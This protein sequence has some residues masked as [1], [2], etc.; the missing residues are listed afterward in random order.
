MLPIIVIIIIIIDCLHSSSFSSSSLS[1]F[2]FS[3]SSSSL[4]VLGN[5]TM[6][7]VS[8]SLAGV[9]G[10][11]LFWCRD[12][13][14]E[15]LCRERFRINS[16]PVRTCILRH[17]LMQ[18]VLCQDLRRNFCFQLFSGQDL[19]MEFEAQKHFGV[20]TCGGKF[21][22]VKSFGSNIFGSRPAS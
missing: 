18:L 2:S 14:V 6:Q 4:V 15:V 9:R 16:F 17:S 19:T 12:L 20:E 8:R 11:E 21:C 7:L 5:L 1:L 10:S 3:S 13:Y 22:V